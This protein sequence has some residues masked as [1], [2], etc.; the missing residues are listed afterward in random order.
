MNRFKLIYA[1]L[2]LFVG[3]AL[4]YIYFSIN[5]TTKNIDTNLEKLYIK[6]AQEHAKNINLEIQKYIKHDLYSELKQDPK[7][8]Q[9]IQSM[10]SSQITSA[11]KYIYILRRD[12]KGSYRYLIDGSHTD[13]G[14]FN[15]RLNVDKKTWNEVYNTKKE[16]LFKHDETLDKLWITYLYPIT[17][18]QQVQ[19]ILAMDFST[20]LP[21]TIKE[22]IQPISHMFLAIFLAII[23][24]ILILFYQTLLTLKTKKESITD[25]LTNVYNRIFLRDF[26][27]KL[28]PEK[29]AILI[30]DIDHFKIINDT[31]GH[32]VGDIVLQKVVNKIKHAIR[33]SDVVVRYGGE[34]FLIFIKRD[35]NNTQECA[36][37]LADRINKIIDSTPFEID[38]LKLHVTVSI[39]V[40]R[41]PEHFKTISSAIKYAD[42]MLY[43]AKRS[44]RN[45]IIF[46]STQSLKDTNLDIEEIKDAIDT[47]RLFCEYQAIVEVSTKK[48]IKY[49]ALVRIRNIDGTIIYPNRFLDIIFNTNL[50]NDMTKQVMEQVFKTI[51]TKNIHLSVNINFSDILNDSIYTIIIQELQ[52]NTKLATFLTIELL[53]YEL[54]ENISIMKE[55][56]EKIKSFG[57]SIAL[58]DFGSGYANYII[59]EALPIDII[60]IDGSLIKEIDKKETSKKITKSIQILAQELNIKTVAEFIHSES[61]YKVIQELGISYG[62]GFYL[63]KPSPHIKTN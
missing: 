38:D 31:Y 7:T 19:G 52:S 40:N 56:L 9:A 36:L 32:K 26:L 23:V 8:I 51:D 44:G 15:Q 60:K 24:L 20:T 59:F 3:L 41:F 54:L 13:K 29:Y 45:K 21:Y 14:E 42:E 10:L 35:K 37:K 63:G 34:E 62:Q 25:Q 2:F 22:T 6:E 46:E 17:I 1:I 28:N 47:N 4:L 11:Y 12:N 57:V 39:G 50:Y 48:I 33:E 18:N 49:E 30:I 27:H 55:R 58:D 53:E 43:I 61:V 5:T 16:K